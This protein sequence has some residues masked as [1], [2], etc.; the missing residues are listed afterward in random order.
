M[1]K[2]PEGA[3]GADEVNRWEVSVAGGKHVKEI[4]AGDFG[5]EPPR[6][7]FVLVSKASQMALVVRNQ[8]AKAADT[9]DVGLI[10]G[11]E[12]SPGGGYGNPLLY[13]CLENPVDRGAWR[14]TVHRVAKSWTRLSD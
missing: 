1:C 5:K 10:P 14:A 2:G 13:S 9:G 7:T 6:V 3:F 8:S 4:V 11:L 12:R